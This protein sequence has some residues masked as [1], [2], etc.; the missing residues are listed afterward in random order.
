MYTSWS[1][2]YGYSVSLVAGAP[3]GEAE[4]NW[5]RYRLCRSTTDWNFANRVLPV[6]VEGCD[7]SESG[8]SFGIHVRTCQDELCSE[9][10]VS[11][12]VMTVTCTELPDVKLPERLRTGITWA[13]PDLFMD[14][15]GG[16]SFF[17]TYKRL[18]L[19][20]VPYSHG[21]FVNLENP[22]DPGVAELD[23]TA[24]TDP[25][26]DGLVFGPVHATFHPSSALFA[27]LSTPD[28]DACQAYTAS[29]ASC[30]CAGDDCPH[31]LDAECSTCVDFA[32]CVC[33][34]GM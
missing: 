5:T 7:P 16:E 27:K 32:S 24:R 2:I 31:C 15:S 11:D 28:L 14:T 19:N 25:K 30:V 4:E 21:H 34:G 17:T 23:V 6:F 20:T 13:Q 10:G 29:G 26:W 1:G 9:P 8:E 22:Q 12:Q 18:G 33:G 3:D